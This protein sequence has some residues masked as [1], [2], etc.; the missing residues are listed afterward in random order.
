MET[1]KQWDIINR[2]N[3]VK[4][5]TEPFVLCP[6]FWKAFNCA[7]IS[8]WSL[9]KLKAGLNKP[10]NKA[11]IYS[12][13]VQPGVASHP[14]CSFLVYIGQT[15]DLARRFGEYL[16]AERSENGR[17]MVLRFLNIYEEHMWFCYMEVA[18]AAL[19]ETEDALIRAYVPPCNSD[20]AGELKAGTK[21][22]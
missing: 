10:P 5:F 17:P 21:A 4:Q 15:V 2:Q 16:G 18:D 14:V 9:L 19:D 7:H 6:K 13:L 1:P 22:F 20:L 12:L 8:K 3:L 11:G